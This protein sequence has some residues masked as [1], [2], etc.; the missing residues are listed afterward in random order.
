MLKDDDDCDIRFQW[1]GVSFS[2]NTAQQ[3]VVWKPMTF[4]EAMK[5]GEAS[6]FRF[7]CNVCFGDR[8]KPF[9]HCGVWEGLFD[10]PENEY[11]MFMKRIRSHML[12]TSFAK[13]LNLNMED[14][15]KEFIYLHSYNMLPTIH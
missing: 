14:F 2:H 15:Q 3:P 13:E 10:L 9:T 1:K 12:K 5:G 7:E 8:L 4:E 6:F 11:N